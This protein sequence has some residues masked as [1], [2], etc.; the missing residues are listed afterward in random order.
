MTSAKF[1]GLLGAMLLA[2]VMLVWILVSLA[3]MVYALTHDDADAAAA[4]ALFALVGVVVA[5]LTWWAGSR[6]AR[7]RAAR[8]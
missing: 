6:V 1:F 5:A 3:A 2:A 4:Y 8:R 7:A